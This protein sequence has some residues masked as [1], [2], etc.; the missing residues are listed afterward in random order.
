[1]GQYACVGCE[2]DHRPG[3]SRLAMLGTG[4][5]AMLVPSSLHAQ[6]LA[7]IPGAG[8]VPETVSAPA[9][10]PAVAAPA[11][12]VS[13]AP[14]APPTSEPINAQVGVRTLVFLQDPD[15]PDKLTDVG[16]T[17]EA[18]VVFSGQVHRFLNWQ[19]G[20]LGMLGESSTTSAAL[21][22][23]VAKVEFADAFNLWVGR[24][25]IPSD[26]TSLSTVWNIAPWTLPGHY[27]RFAAILPVN[28][29]PP[30][31]PRGGELGRGDG[32]TLWGQFRG[33]RFKYYLGAFGLDQPERSPLYSA[34][35]SLSL[36]NPEPGFRTSSTYNGG[37]DVLAFGVGA[38]HRTQGSRPPPNPVVPAAPTDFDD[39]NADVLLEIGS[40]TA[41]VLD[42]EGAFAK[43]W[44]SQEVVGYQFFALVSYLVPLDVG[45][46]RFQ[47]LVR[48]QHAGPGPAEDS[49][50]F[51]SIDTQLG[52]VIDGHHARL[53][54]SW[55]YTR[56]GGQVQ[57]AILLGLQLLSKDR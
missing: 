54:T 50:D 3:L 14:Q 48:V 52:Y 32:A 5:V 1:M 42:L 39:V 47:P 23:L 16:A 38:Q 41:G 56:V 46:G 22:D 57:N 26:R 31:G 45:F 49:G 7:E 10:A 17:G 9:P 15:A 24:M 13:A 36:L 21:L 19:A 55:Q 27:L 18:D 2:S 53:C 8:V 28:A 20:F 34:R 43:L 11:P 51:T 6:S 29:R 12:E 33:G 30:A 4:L 44:G 37:K 35:L 25:P 40:A